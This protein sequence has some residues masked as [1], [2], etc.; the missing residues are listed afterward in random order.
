[1]QP[2]ALLQA[3]SHFALSPHVTAQAAAP[4]HVTSQLSALQVNAG[5]A[6]VPHAAGHA[7]E[8]LLP[9]QGAHAQFGGGALGGGGAVVGGGGVPT[10]P[11]DP[12]E[13]PLPLDPLAP[14]SPSNSA[15]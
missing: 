7:N 5:H 8:Q 9:V 10:L 12:E 13:P 14:P 11:L 3:T 4:V 1:M 6:H 2:P 15:S